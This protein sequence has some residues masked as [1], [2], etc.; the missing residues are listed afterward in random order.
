MRRD[1]QT[2]EIRST[3]FRSHMNTQLLYDFMCVLKIH[4]LCS[5][6]DCR[7]VAPGEGQQEE[8]AGCVNAASRVNWKT[9]N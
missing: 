8:A 5:P 7:L 4:S 6:K 2:I 9:Y 3:G 1:R